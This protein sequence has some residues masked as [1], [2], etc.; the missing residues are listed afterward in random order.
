MTYVPAP[1]FRRLAA[2]ILDLTFCLLLTFVVAI[3]VSIVF[4]PI[5]L[6][7]DESR[8]DIAVTIGAWLCYFIAYVGLE[9]FLLVR[10]DG[11]TLGKGLLGLRVVHS[12]PRRPRITLLPAVGRM[13]IIFLPFV[14]T[15]FAGRYPE[16]GLLNAISIIGLLSIVI[17][18]IL[19]AVPAR[20]RRALHDLAAGS[21]VVRAEVRKIRLR[22][23]LPMVLPGKV[24]M[25]KRY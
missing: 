17:S 13:L 20:G 6:S 14:F 25:T 9:V 19:A 8:R 12:D 3:P 1:F 21:R 2:R 4:V 24:D 11:Q 18:L 5:Q 23:D 10:R 16:A 7:L 22:Q 15:S